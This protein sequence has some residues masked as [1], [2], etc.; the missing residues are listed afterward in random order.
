MPWA[1]FVE[2]V[3]RFSALK[4]TLDSFDWKSFFD[5]RT[6][7]YK[8][9]EVKTARHFSWCNIGPALPREIGQVALEDVCT[10]GCRHY[11]RNFSCYLKPRCRWVSE[12]PPK[13]MVADEDWG[14]V[15]KNLVNCGLCT[16]LERDQ[17][18]DTGNGLL[19]NGL[20]GVS[21]EEW[22]HGTEIFRLIM[23][24][25]PLN[26]LCLPLA[27][28]VDTLPSWSLMS[29]FFLQPSETLL[30][31]SEDV[32][33]FFY[34]LSVPE[35]WWPFL[36]FNKVV[37]NEALPTELQDREV[38][39]ASRV[40]P[41]GFLNSVSLAQHVHR[42]LVRWSGRS[43]VG[44]PCNLAADELRK[45]KGFPQSKKPWRV[46]LDNY[47]LLEKVESTNM[48][49][50][51]GSVAP[52]VFALRHEYEI[53]GIPR[54][55]KKSVQR[56]SLCEMQ[57]AQVDGTL[58]V[59]YPRETKLLKYLAAAL[60]FCQ[61]QMVTQKQTQVVCGGLVYF[62]MFRRPLLGGLN[63]VWKFIEEFNQGGTRLRPLPQAC[64]VELLRFLALLPL[65]RID[66]RLP[67]EGQV[68][69]SDASTL[70]GGLCASVGV[71]RAGSLVSQGFLRG[72]VEEPTFLA[73]S[74]WKRILWLH[75]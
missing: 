14:E 39:L 56:S 51:K 55:E 43:E 62:S 26:N 29:P 18:F 54:N 20:F 60:K 47:D 52:G 73:M 53:W 59:A 50:T 6:I 40:L 23:N 68:T 10:E 41:M 24:L 45:D 58:G 9:D 42:N 63:A 5:T 48:V 61:S 71:T 69:C 65:A 75:G 34:T 37:P 49:A 21:K 64:R 17:V 2:D 22:S 67:I 15:C 38:Y 12:R 31:S 13:V 70:G 35:E 44:S 7:D 1:P 46:Y 25:I 30:V 11:V 36:A 28:D 8:G 32:R 4:G 3:L 16:F 27:G 57:G 19:L 74:A 66:F 33:C 72:E